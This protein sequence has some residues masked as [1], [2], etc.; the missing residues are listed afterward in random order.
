MRSPAEQIEACICI[1]PVT[2][3][4]YPGV[5]SNVRPE[6]LFTSR[7]WIELRWVGGRGE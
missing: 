2:L 4:A 7:M 3:L 6:S 5:G 1:L